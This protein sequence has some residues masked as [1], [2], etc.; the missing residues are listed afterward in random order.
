MI[1]MVR[2]VVGWGWQKSLD[3]R[4]WQGLGFLAHSLQASLVF[5]GVPQLD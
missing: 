3:R 1:A 5:G 4:A 2:V